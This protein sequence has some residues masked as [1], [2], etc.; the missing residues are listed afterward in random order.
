[1]ICT[2]SR[3]SDSSNHQTGSRR[4]CSR[5]DQDES[6]I[7]YSNDPVH[8]LESFS[9]GGPFFIREAV[10]VLLNVDRSVKDNPNFERKI[11]LVNI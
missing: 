8:W 11:L 6:S 1:M 2:A 4:T 10:Q 3:P 5:C 7:V 9:L